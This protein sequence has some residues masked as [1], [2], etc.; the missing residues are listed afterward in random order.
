MAATKQQGGALTL[1]LVGLTVACI[2]VALS[3][4]RGKLILLVGIVL[5]AV[6]CWR[7]FQLKPL[8]GRI[9]LKSQPAVTKLIGLIVVLLGWGVVLFGLHLTDSVGG[10]MTTSVVGLVISLA[11]V[12][13]ILPAACN[14]NAIWKA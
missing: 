14:K 2:G 1:F 6:S 9:A 5:L 4:G 12:L 10:R 8:E 7:F 13:F 11:G 3:G